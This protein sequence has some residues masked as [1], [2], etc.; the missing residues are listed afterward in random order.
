MARK[1][2]RSPIRQLLS[3]RRIIIPIT[4]GLVVAGYLLYNN[5]TEIRFEEAMEPQGNYTWTDGNGDG[6]VDY[7]SEGDFT[8]VDEGTGKYSKKQ[9]VDGK[10]R[11]YED[12][13]YVG[14]YDWED[15]NGNGE[16]EKK[17]EKEFVATEAGKGKYRKLTYRDTLE[18]VD[19]T[20]YSTFWLFMA[21][22]LTAVRD[23]AY[24]FRLRTLTNGQ[25]SWRKCFD[26]IMLWEFAS[27]VTPSV[28]GGSPIAIFLV[29]KEGINVGRSTALVMVTA[30]MDEIFY[31]TMVP[32]VYFLIADGGGSIFVEG[33]SFSFLNLSYGTKVLFYISYGFVVVYSTFLLYGIF[34]NPK[35]VKSIIVGIFKLPFLRRWKESAIRTGNEL[36]EASNELRGQSFGFWAKVVGATY[37]SW[38]ARY[39][40]VNCLI[41][42]VAVIPLDQFLIYGRQLVMWMIM[43]VS[44]TPGGSG[45][46]EFAFSEYLTEF[47]PVGLDS[48][49]AI[50]WRMFSYYPYIFIGAIL[51]PRWLRRVYLKRKL[52]RF[53]ST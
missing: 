18:R 32:I 15:S 4:I 13:I 50:I 36:V 7:G 45:L 26:V 38:T 46:A 5:L 1:R 21:L 9:G 33:Q 30:M 35:G 43:L 3:P 44:P 48:S 42:A 2:K 6:V 19:W 47:I 49:L 23:L 53:K 37:F 25:L 29:N 16:I 17:N 40:V 24:M 39:F 52:I 34:Y 8:L 22:V 28:V 20:W 27:S 11:F 41:L 14:D 31:V 51:L 12:F 10:V